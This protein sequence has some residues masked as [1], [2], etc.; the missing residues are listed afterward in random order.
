MAAEAGRPEG[1]PSGGSEERPAGRNG[2]RSRPGPRPAGARR[3]R[4]G[5]GPERTAPDSAPEDRR[6]GAGDRDTP[7][8]HDFGRDG[9][10][11]LVNHDRAL[12]AREVSRPRPE[13]EADAAAGAEAMLKR[14]GRHR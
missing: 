1:S 2:D 14:L 3:R 7:L 8:P 6:G 5:P 10:S 9:T 4:S 11:G 13:D 12:R